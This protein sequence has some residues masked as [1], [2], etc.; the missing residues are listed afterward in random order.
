MKKRGLAYIGKIQHLHSARKHSNTSSME[1]LLFID[2]TG[3]INTYQSRENTK[4]NFKKR[5]K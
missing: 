4:R 5:R 2:Q 1:D 3:R